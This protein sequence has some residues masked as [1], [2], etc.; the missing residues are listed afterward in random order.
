MVFDRVRAAELQ[1]LGWPLRDIARELK[2][3]TM[4]VQRALRGHVP[5]LPLLRGVPPA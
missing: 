4:T 2:V 5:R 3:S 1:D